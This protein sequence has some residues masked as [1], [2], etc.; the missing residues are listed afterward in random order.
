MTKILTLNNFKLSRKLKEAIKVGLSF[1]IVYSIALKIGW[2]NPYWAGLAIL[3]LA[4]APAGQG[5][6]KGF[7][8]AVGT[9]IAVIVALAIFSFA[10]QDR[11]LFIGLITAWMFFTTYM[12]LK[13]TQHNYLWNSAGFIC[14]VILTHS[15]DSS[16]SIF[17]YAAARVL[18]TGMGIIVFTIVTVFVWPQTNITTLKEISIDVLSA[19]IKLLKL[20]VL[21][22]NSDEGKKSQLEL[23]K[24]HIMSLKSLQA[25]FYGKGSDSYEL[26]KSM[27]LWKKFHYLSTVLRKTTNQLHNG[28]YGFLHIDIYKLVP[29]VEAYK[30]EIINRLTIALKLQKGDKVDYEPKEIKLEIN[31]EYLNSL[32]AFDKIAFSAAKKELQSIDRVSK[33]I[34]QSIK[35][36]LNPSTI[37][38]V[39]DYKEKQNIYHYFILDRERLKASLQVGFSAFFGFLVWIYIDPPHHT[40]WYSLLPTMSM[41]VAN[42]PQINMSK[43]L[44]P[45]FFSML[46]ALFIYVVIMPHLSGYLSLAILLGVSITVIMCYFPP[47]SIAFGFASIIL[48][49]SVENEQ[50]YDFATEANSFVFLL[51]IF[52]FTFVLSYIIGS[53][54]PE[55]VALSMLHRYFK[56]AELLISQLQSED[57]SFIKKLKLEYYFYELN[58]L[59]KKIDAWTKAINYVKFSQ[60]DSRKVEYLMANIYFLSTALEELI[61]SSRLSQAEQIPKETHD[62]IHKWRMAIKEIFKEYS[63]DLDKDPSLSMQESLTR[64]RENLETSINKNLSEFKLSE[65]SN[66]EKEHISQLIGSYQGLALSL[67]SYVQV[68]RTVKFNTW[69]E[70]YFS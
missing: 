67:I 26:N 70:E 22:I 4:I 9:I 51:L 25:T 19:Q 56:N 5:I 65:I 6:H 2:M 43:A 13:D 49:V 21:D 40:M 54:R 60:N 29:N 1:A 52:L 53:S 37:R 7:F 39:D 3:V 10:V 12:M 36:L 63:L 50:V 16:A 48:L 33:G 45:T 27:P 44:V 28:T 64:Y 46:Y 15:P 55:K 14:I 30:Q 24:Q 66:Q 20:N 11:W 34:L 18:E 62:E 57:D 69:Y 61:K 41:I 42:Y 23:S 68:A 59:P 58:T 8:R 47:K 38:I 17:D 31:S 32:S 35:D